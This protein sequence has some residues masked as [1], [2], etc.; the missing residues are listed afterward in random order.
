MIV[1]ICKRDCLLCVAEKLNSD[2][3]VIEITGVSGTVPVT[4][5]IAGGIVAAIIIITLVIVI[6]MLWYVHLF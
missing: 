5:A 1:A 4:V 6:I 3:F 2:V